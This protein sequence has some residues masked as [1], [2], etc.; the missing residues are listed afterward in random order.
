[1][2]RM[3]LNLIFML[4]KFAHLPEQEKFVTQQNLAVP[5][6]AGTKTVMDHRTPD[7]RKRNTSIKRTTWAAEHFQHLNKK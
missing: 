2:N 3:V 5:I 7:H 6:L 4:K 1:M